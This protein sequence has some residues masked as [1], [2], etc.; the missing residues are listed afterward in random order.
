METIAA[1]SENY[2]KPINTLYGQNAKL[3]NVKA[4]GT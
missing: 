1:Y 2:M 4:G 3:Q